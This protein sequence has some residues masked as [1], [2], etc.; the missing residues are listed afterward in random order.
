[1]ARRMGSDSTVNSTATN[2][3]IDA[4]GNS[5]VSGDA[6]YGG[7][8]LGDAAMNQVL[9]GIPNATFSLLPRD[10]TQ[11]IDNTDNPL[12]YWYIE[13]SNT[14]AITVQVVYNEAA[15]SYRLRIDPSRAVAGDTLTLSTKTKIR[16]DE[17]GMLKQYLLG[18]VYR[19]GTAPGSTQ[20]GVVVENYYLDATNATVEGGA[21]LFD[22]YDTTSAASLADIAEQTV[23]TSSFV[24]PSATY[25]QLKMVISATATVT[26]NVTLDVDTLFVDSQYFKPVNAL[27]FS[28][29]GQLAVSTAK[30]DWSVLGVGAD[31]EVLTADSAE[32]TGMKW[33]A[34]G[35][36][37]G[38][39]PLTLIDAKGDLIVG[40]APDTAIRLAVG[41][42]DEQL[43]A[44]STVAG[45]VAWGPAV[46]EY[47]ETFETS[48]TWT[49]PTGV[50]YVTVIA[51][52]AGGGGGGGAA[53]A[54]VSSTGTDTQTQGGG[55]GGSG[56]WIIVRNL[57]VGDLSTVSV[58]IGARGSGGN[59]ATATKAAG[60]SAV[61]FANGTA[62]SAGGSTTFGSLLTLGGGGGG[63]G[64]LANNTANV[65]SAG[66]IA[67]TITNTTFGADQFLGTAGGTGSN[68]G[69]SGN[70][71]AATNF[72]VRLWDRF[73]YFSQ[74]FALGESG[75][76]GTAT[77]PAGGTTYLGPAGVASNAGFFGAGG[78]GGR[79]IHASAGDGGSAYAGG[80]GG[81]GG[82]GSRVGSTA[83]AAVATGGWGGDSA[84][85][86]SDTVRV[87]GGGG[88][89]G[90]A[91]GWTGSGSSIRNAS[92][93]N[94]TG[95]SGGTG[96]IARLIVVYVY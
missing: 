41:A 66:G 54:G 47:S 85:Y 3:V 78:G 14:D 30:K 87:G 90:G 83:G 79:A 53:A 49:R 27:A 1:M 88:G 62:G 24:D 91:L 92:S 32:L 70:S 19:N 72:G 21:G 64:G 68:N 44:D 35:G 52:G 2:G 8:P 82:A 39:I 20:W 15:N 67:G 5:I 4:Y 11:P 56:G 16:H 7:Q 37:G 84:S 81:G 59:G 29:K 58:G 9:F 80:G 63:A 60:V 61:V 40:S 51:V 50:D 12:P 65:I 33:A 94:S 26:S 18:S 42:D 75:G 57:Y 48:G 36:G 22:F 55:G 74:T 95:G 38:G 28:E 77:V 96:D 13:E 6:S 31:G 89:G 86:L 71:T 43:F 23:T 34:A 46:R 69:G 73:P 93:F 45:G 76:A 17:G 10:I 25:L